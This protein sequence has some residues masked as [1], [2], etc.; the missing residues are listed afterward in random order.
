MNYDD[1]QK[2]V[3]G[4]LKENQTL[5]RM[6]SVD[7]EADL[8]TFEKP[9]QPILSISTARRVD[10]K[11]D[12]KKFVLENETGEDEARIF[13]EF[14]SF[15]QEVKPLVLLGYGLS[16]FDLPVMMLKI[17]ILEKQFKKDGKYQPGYWSI[18]ETMGR[19]YFLDILDPVRFEIGKFDNVSP[20]FV[21]L[22]NAI[23]HA[24][25]NKIPFMNTKN[26]VS[27]LMT[28]SGM[29]KW[30]AIHSLWENDR[31]DFNKYI[32]GDVHDTLLLAE[33][34]FGIMRNV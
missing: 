23:S 28:T 6:V 8:G 24:R 1:F 4:S 2:I 15:C 7:I 17:R 19:S 9:Q 21:R 10:G 11:I 33:N 27:D 22:E 13:N 12:I 20:K 34:L 25:F 29:D 30:N 31:S 32:E 3:I 5:D 18:R 26:V 14:G 16:G